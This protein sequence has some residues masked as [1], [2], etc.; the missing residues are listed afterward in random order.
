M[1]MMF[2]GTEF[3]P[4]CGARTEVIAEGAETQRKCPRCSVDLHAIQIASTPLEE[5]TTCGGLW[6][7]VTNFEKL[8]ADAESRQA[9]TG[10]A[11]PPPVPFDP[12]V[13]Y[14]KCPRCAN[15]MNRMNYAQRSG[16]VINVCKPHGIWLDRDEIR[17]IIQFISSGGLDHARQIETE[18]FNEARRSAGAVDFDAPGEAPLGSSYQQSLNSDD[19]EH[20]VN[21]IASLANHFLGNRDFRL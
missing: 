2:S 20:L 8:C 1:G 17:Q 18:E 14:L 5:C 19:R 4:H 11:L 16:I 9:A 12:S 7:D 21:G 15:I 6:V 13:R 3:C 10:L